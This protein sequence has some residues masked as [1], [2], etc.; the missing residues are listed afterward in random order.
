MRTT[1]ELLGLAA[2]IDRGGGA[3]QNR[4]LDRTRRVE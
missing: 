2:L 4:L 1:M 3:P